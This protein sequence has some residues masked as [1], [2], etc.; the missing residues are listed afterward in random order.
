MGHKIYPTAERTDL[1]MSASKSKK[2]RK[3]EAALGL[4][5]K[6]K[7]AIAAE[8]KA[9]R[10]KLIYA[11]V[12]VVVVICIAALL[13]WDSGIIQKNATAVTVGSQSYKAVD[14]DYYYNS[15]LSSYSSYASLYGLDLEKPLDEQ[16]ISEG[17]TWDQMLRDAAI[18]TLTN[19][20]MLADAAAAEG[21]TL[22]DEGKHEVE[23]AISS[24]EVYA[25]LYS[26]SEDYFLQANYG[27]YMTMDEFERILTKQQ[28][29][30]EY[31]SHK[32][33]SFE[34]T[35][36]E[37]EENYKENAIS[38]DTIDYDCYLLSVATTEKDADG[39]TVDLDE[40][41]IEANRTAAKA[42][43]QE[44][45]DA[46]TSGDA[47][48]AESLAKEYGASTYSN[49]P[50]ITYY[51]YADWL[52]T[53]N[54][55]SGAVVD[56]VNSADEVTGYYAIYVND[57]HLDEYHGA[58]IRVLSFTASADDEGN[59]DMDAIVEKAEKAKVDFEATAKDSA[60]FKTVYESVNGSTSHEGHEHDD[61]LMENVSK[62]YYGDAV[63]EWV[64]DAGRKTGDYTLITDESA[65][66]CY[67]I[68][69][70]GT[71]DTP[72]WK[73]VCISNVQNEKYSAWQEEAMKAY[74]VTEGSGMK[75]VG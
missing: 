23:S 14:V 20:T 18:D 32:M 71:S 8:A 75:Y 27:K 17:V 44:I 62:D 41:T 46:L 60:G 16:E 69:F 70:E 28:L 2:E 5:E 6:Q 66:A 37:I 47:E 38:L 22:S 48:T 72:Y 13:F 52:S 9:K 68:Y 30:A 7:Q 24:I 64:F 43:A 36:A 40:A 4:T 45:L 63:N 67:L 50:Y 49:S 65:H 10:N 31:S 26:V 58:N 59:Y 51:A 73:T 33:E 34:I 54:A 74:T 11:I 29:A 3:A 35:D 53:H 55:G 25:A 15:T 12:G 42:H 39:N 57:R 21:F 19:I 1:F 61:S 56:N